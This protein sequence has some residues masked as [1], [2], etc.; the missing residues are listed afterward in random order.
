VIG[1]VNCLSEPVA[2]TMHVG[3]SS[4]PTHTHTQRASA[5]SQPP[6]NRQFHLVSCYTSMM[7]TGLYAVSGSRIGDPDLDDG[8]YKDRLGAPLGYYI[9]S[10]LA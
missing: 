6:S 4:M 2:F 8:V 3:S 1:V 7:A 5:P 10:G 9:L